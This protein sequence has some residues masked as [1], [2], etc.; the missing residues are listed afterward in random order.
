M[1]GLSGPPRA[2]RKSGPSWPGRVGAL[3]EIGGDRRGDRRQ[4]RDDALLV[5]LAAHAQRVVGAAAAPRRASPPA[6]RRCAGRSRRAAPGWRRCAPRSTALRRA[7]S[8]P[9]WSPARRRW[10]AAWAGCAWRAA[11][12]WRAAPRRWRGRRVRGRRR[13]ERMPAMPRAS[14]REPAPSLRRCGH[15]GADIGGG[16]RA[17]VGE[18]RR[19][20]EMAGEEAQEL[21]D[22]ARIG[23][24]RLVGQPPL[25]GKMPPPALDGLGEAGRG[26][27]ERGVGRQR[28]APWRECR[29]PAG[30]GRVN[31]GCRPRRGNL[32]LPPAAGP[33]HYGPT[34]ETARVREGGHHG[35]IHHTAQL[36]PCGPLR[37][38]C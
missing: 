26:E 20:A 1:R 14:V 25:A 16:K 5:A 2:P 27:D 33:A 22:V 23:L 24:D 36:W 4:H 7:R 3:A 28:F 19:V 12:G 9:R 11:G 34:G 21:V 17:H 10:S 30:E 32:A 38:P 37:R 13:S 15:E 31:A 18:R 8:R 6:P 35:D 29:P